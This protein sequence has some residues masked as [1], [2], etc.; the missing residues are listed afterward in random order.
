VID[1][2]EVSMW[3][4]WLGVLN[5]CVGGCPSA[6]LWC[7]VVV[8]VVNERCCDGGAMCQSCGIGVCEWCMACL[9]DTEVLCRV[10]GVLVVVAGA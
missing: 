10:S 1:V 2:V 8:V 7:S 3:V 5:W 4:K 6:R 9:R